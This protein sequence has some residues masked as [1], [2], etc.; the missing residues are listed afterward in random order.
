MFIVVILYDV[1]DDD[2]AELGSDPGWLDRD[3]K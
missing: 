3:V 1:I 2:D